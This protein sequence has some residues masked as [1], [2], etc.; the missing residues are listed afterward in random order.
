MQFI[1]FQSGVIQFLK[2][3]VEENDKD[4]HTDGDPAFSI[5]FVENKKRQ[6]PFLHKI[7]MSLDT[8]I[9]EAAEA[10]TPRK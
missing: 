7:D 1:E 8:V 3:L 2:K 10:V 9:A 4:S 6:A 5:F